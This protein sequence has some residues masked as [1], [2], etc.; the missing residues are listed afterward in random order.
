M[1]VLFGFSV[2]PKLLL[3]T[4]FANHK[5]A[6]ASRPISDNIEL[7]TSGFHCDVDNLVVE[8]PFLFEYVT[9]DFT[10]PVLFGTYQDRPIQHCCPPENHISFLRGPPSM[11]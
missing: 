6:T 7:S 8:S 1:L 3:H 2:T 4:L 10:T 5:D 11:A 9:L